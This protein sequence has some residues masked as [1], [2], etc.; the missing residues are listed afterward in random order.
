MTKLSTLAAA[1][2]AGLVLS[3]AA[4]GGPSGGTSTDDDA[5]APSE[6]RETEVQTSDSSFENGVLTTPDLV[7]EITGHRV[8]SPGDVGNEYGDKPVIGF[9]YN[10]TNVSGEDITPLDW[11]YTFEAVQ[12]NNPDAV[13]VLEI[14]SLPDDRFLDTQMESIKQG[15][16]VENAVAYELDDLTTPVE[17]I[18]TDGLADDEIGR[19]T[20]ALQ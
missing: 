2:C 17:L 11:I 13:N 10:I 1:A 19:Q 4:C 7:I 15:G 5:R 3:L 16:T 18:A 12:D 6:A 8:I 20:F 9:W 14:G